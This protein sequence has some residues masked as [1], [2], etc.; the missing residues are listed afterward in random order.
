MSW[1]VVQT[2]PG[3]NY[4]DYPQN[5]WRRELPLALRHFSQ[6][7]IEWYNPRYRRRVR[8]GYRRSQLFPSYVF[9]R[10]QWSVVS[11]T[12]GVREVLGEV[13]N[14]VVDDIKARHD[15]GGYVQLNVSKF[16][17]G[18][19]VVMKGNITA[20]FDGQRDRD[21]VYVLMKILGSQRRV[22]CDEAILVAA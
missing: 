9:V 8:A 2:Q 18:Q 16:R 5:C 20:L 1:L 12:I 4:H 11:N 22:E 17:I 3:I 7:N 10:G 14:N 15:P 6:Q 21:R 19:Q 13:P